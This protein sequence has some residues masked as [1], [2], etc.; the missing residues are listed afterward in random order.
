MDTTLTLVLGKIMG[1]LYDIQNRQGVQNVDNGHIYGL[2]H[3]FEEA[4][5]KEFEGLAVV[6]QEEVEAVYEYFDSFIQAETET[7]KLPSFEDMRSHME[8]QDIGQDRFITILRYLN[9]SDK[10]NVDVNEFGNFELTDS[11]STGGVS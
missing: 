11:R 4:L 1:E 3:G 9:A 5:L 2:K 6:R 10:I 8:K 7:N